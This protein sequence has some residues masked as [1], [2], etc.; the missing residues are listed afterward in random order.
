MFKDLRA[1][2]LIECTVNGIARQRLIKLHLEFRFVNFR[3]ERDNQVVQFSTKRACKTLSRRSP[4]PG[5]ERFRSIYVRYR[6]IN[7]VWRPI[8][9]TRGQDDNFQRAFVKARSSGQ[10]WKGNNTSRQREDQ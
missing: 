9:A 2:R 10:S 4:P 7:R 6:D 1:G 8:A 5:S 3:V